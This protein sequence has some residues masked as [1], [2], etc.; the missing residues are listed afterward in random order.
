MHPSVLAVPF[1]SGN[2]WK[3]TV[4]EAN[5]AHHAQVADH[6]QAADHAWSAV[7]AKK[8]TVATSMLKV[9]LRGPC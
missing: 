9:K 8:N 5:S 7:V 2:N 4:L 6:A 3:N 1:K